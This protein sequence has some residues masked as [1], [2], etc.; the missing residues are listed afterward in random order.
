MVMKK[1]KRQLHTE[2]YHYRQRVDRVF[3]RVFKRIERTDVHILFDINNQITL[4]GE[5]ARFVER[6]TQTVS[7]F[8]VCLLKR[9]VYSTVIYDKSLGSVVAVVS[10]SKMMEDEIL[11]SGCDFRSV[12]RSQVA[13][14]Y[15]RDYRDG[16]RNHKDKR[17]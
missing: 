9:G 7:V 6:L 5:G 16:K 13:T 10:F 11:V 2:L 12:S 1:E 17:V 4:N 15:I 8:N 3:C 14:N